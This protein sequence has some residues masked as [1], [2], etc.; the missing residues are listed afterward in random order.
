LLTACATEPAKSPAPPPSPATDASAAAAPAAAAIAVPEQ[1]KG[2]VV[3]YRPSGFAG[4]AIGFIVR[5][6]TTELGKLRSGKYF[7]LQVAPGKHTYVVHSEAKDELT[8]DVD[9]GET[10]YI[11][12]EVGMG[13]LVGHP[14]IKP[15]DKNGF[16]AAKSKMKQVS[17]LSG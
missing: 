3:F 12:G 9:A 10:Y 6:G 4:A 16:D 17:P 14:H 7:V 13:I 5:E 1:G 15:S 11:E 8:I 2:M